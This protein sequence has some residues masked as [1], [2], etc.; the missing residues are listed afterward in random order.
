MIKSV[1]N[2][3]AMMSRRCQE[4]MAMPVKEIAQI[5]F[6]DFASLYNSIQPTISSWTYNAA[7]MQEFPTYSSF[8]RMGHPSKPDS[9][10]GFEGFK[11]FSNK[12]MFDFAQ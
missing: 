9:Y 5:P 11:R 12:S 6:E 8:C 10:K 1:D 3:L 4:L 2:E 7:D